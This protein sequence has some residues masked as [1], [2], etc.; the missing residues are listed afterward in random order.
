MGK[1]KVEIL[2]LNKTVVEVRQP[3]FFI[4]QVQD[5]MKVNCTQTTTFIINNLLYN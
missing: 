5:N 4:V 1:E 3:F 2:K